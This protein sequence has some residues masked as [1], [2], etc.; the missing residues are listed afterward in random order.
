MFLCI[1]ILI[2]ILPGKVDLLHQGQSRELPSSLTMVPRDDYSVVIKVC[3]FWRMDH[4][5]TPYP[6]HFTDI[7]QGFLYPVETGVVL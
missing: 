5:K 3:I 4:R 1:M 2:L 6:C 7:S